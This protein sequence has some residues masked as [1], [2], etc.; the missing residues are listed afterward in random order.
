[1][2][3]CV[4]VCVFVCVVSMVNS[5]VLFVAY[6]GCVKRKKRL[7]TC[8]KCADSD[9]LAHAQSIIRAFALHYYIL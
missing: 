3:V 1:M 9:H 6:L 2:C 7:R 5:H 4:S 8:A